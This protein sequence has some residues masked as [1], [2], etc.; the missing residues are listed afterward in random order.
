MRTLLPS[1]GVN[2]DRFGSAVSL[3]SSTFVV[4]SSADDTFRG[5]A[6][7]FYIPFELY[8]PIILKS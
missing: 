5:S 3:F 1:D 6:Y 4:G 7:I 2:G 8:L